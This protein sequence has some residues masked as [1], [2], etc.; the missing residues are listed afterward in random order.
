MVRLREVL[1]AVGVALWTL[2]LVPAWDQSEDQGIIHKRFCLGWW[3]SPFLESRDR[4]D[5]SKSA[6]V[7]YSGSTE[8][9]FVSWSALALLLGLLAFVARDILKAV[10]SRSNQIESIKPT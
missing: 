2:A 9:R 1:L 3:N 10:Y 5:E 8:I 6:T 4:I 7:P